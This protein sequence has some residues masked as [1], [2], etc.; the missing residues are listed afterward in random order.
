MPR[1]IDRSISCCRV[2]CLPVFFFDF[3]GSLVVASFEAVGAGVVA[4][5]AGGG[6]VAAHGAGVV[7]AADGTGVGA[8]R[9]VAAGGG[10]ADGAGVVVS[11]PA[12]GGV[13]ASAMFAGKDSNAIA[14]AVKKSLCMKKL[15]GC[16][17]PQSLK[18]NPAALQQTRWLR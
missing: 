17:G 13:C 9:G 2:I 3:A 6:V 5:A 4:A 8:G 14:V 15:Q 10:A 12:L 16:P 11:V 7:V 1:S 18:R